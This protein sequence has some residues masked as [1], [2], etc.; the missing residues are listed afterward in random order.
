M[1]RLQ[2][3]KDRIESREARIGVIGL[4][5]VGLPLALEF[6]KAGFAVI[7]IDAHHFG[8]RAPRGL[9][10]IPDEFDPFELT[11]DED[12]KMV[13][14]VSVLRNVALTAPYFHDRRVK[15][16]E[17]AVRTK[18]TIQV[19]RNFTDEQIDD[20][21]AFLKTLSDKLRVKE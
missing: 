18:A 19:D 7:V 3:L 5:Y 21:V 15:T 10:G 8:A 11:G 14:K 2:E 9:N 1:T 6:A 17:E 13:F 4:G 12:D 16:L 20:I